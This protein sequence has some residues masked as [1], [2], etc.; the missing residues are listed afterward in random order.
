MLLF[1]YLPGYQRIIGNP[2]FETNAVITD[3]TKDTDSLVYLEMSTDDASQNDVQCI[4]KALR[5]NN[6]VQ[7]LIL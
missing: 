2:T 1:P 4:I 6:S 3:A 7:E 5:F